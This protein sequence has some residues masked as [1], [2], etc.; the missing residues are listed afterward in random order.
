MHM[1]QAIK[2]VN[3]MDM[4]SESWRLVSGL[5][6]L[7]FKRYMLT[8]LLVLVTV[9]ISLLLFGA[10]VMTGFT[11][12]KA[13]FS[14]L[15]FFE[16]II[17]AYI[18]VPAIILGVRKAINMSLDINQVK[19][20]CKSV[21][22]GL[23]NIIVMYSAMATIIDL[24]VSLTPGH[25]MIVLLFHV[26]LYCVLFLFSLPLFIFALP[27]II[28]RKTNVSAGLESA[29]RNMILYW[30]EIIGSY[31]IL[32]AIPYF[33]NMIGMIF[34]RQVHVGLFALIALM[35]IVGM[36]WLLPMTFTLGGVLFREVYGLKSAKAA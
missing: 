35:L 28:I 6:W 5:K 33:V 21:Q 36:I 20:E 14:L 31:F 17:G 26:S 12:A 7:I 32:L 24:L 9:A 11:G 15:L 25:D 19:A 10:Q 18:W 1:S 30:K 22:S 27:L 29:Y 34:L 2:R 4:L 8:M 16:G 3:I 13:I 23:L